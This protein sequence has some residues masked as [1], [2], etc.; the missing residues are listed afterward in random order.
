VTSSGTDTVIR[1][2]RVLPAD[3]LPEFARSMVGATL[4]VV[5]T[6]TWGPAA[7]DGSR[8]GRVEM[9]VAGVPVTLDG[10]LRLAP[11]GPGTVESLDAELKARLPLIGGKVEKAAAPA[12]RD[13]IEVEGRTAREWLARRGG[14]A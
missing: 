6:Q 3:D 14:D 7:A 5:E 9:A 12:I 1:T 2:E 8:S 11:G 10:S 4:K 13:A